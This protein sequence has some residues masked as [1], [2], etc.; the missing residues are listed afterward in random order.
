[1]RWEG[2]EAALSR[3]D[4]QD[5]DYSAYMPD[6]L[7]GRSLLLD[8]STTAEVA[9]AEAA[10][11]RLQ[12]RERAFFNTETVARLLL[13][14]ECVASSRIEGL[15]V[16]AR[17]LLRAEAAAEGGGSKHQKH[18][19]VTA[20]EVL[21]NIEAMRFG[22][23][24]VGPQDPITLDILLEIH[25]RLLAGSSLAPHGG[26]L[27]ETQNWIGGHGLSP[28]GAVF[29]PPPQE[30]V[31][32]LCE[33]LMAFCNSNDV[34][35]VVQAAMAHAQFEIIHPFADGNG[36]TGRALIHLVLRRRGLVIDVLP[37]IS[38]VL[39][40][41]QDAYVAGLRAVTYIGDATSAEALAGTNLWICRFA[42]ACR[43]AV[44]D[45]DFYL[46]R[47]EAIRVRWRQQ[48]GSVRTKSAAALLID[49]L[50]S[51]PL[52][53]VGTAAKL[54]GRS[55]Q[56]T[57]EALARF[58]AA[59]IV[60]QTNLGKRNRAFEAEAV[61]RAF[62]ELERRLASPLGDT[63]AAKPSRPIPFRR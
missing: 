55:F 52:L 2:A 10:I 3:Q 7:C 15:Q 16:N 62:T 50:I 17:R 26:L 49:A 43:R 38:L 54:I 31:G 36:R 40:T 12:M 19:D 5:F 21:A 47:A 4:R 18:Q 11:G 44:S 63:V 39:A 25:R 33:D 56:Q 13:R 14:A 34:S 24:A 28:R 53:T 45:V 42:A 32:G 27:R 1:M 61:I 57:N 58:E 37:P 29:V 51:T 41:M 9:E 30:E 8:A 22:Y 46:E 20:R 35:V 59:G 60:K 23:K 48:L 6:R